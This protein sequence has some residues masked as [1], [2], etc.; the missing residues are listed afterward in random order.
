[1]EEC[2]R[3]ARMNG[4]LVYR[5]VIINLNLSGDCGNYKIGSNCEHNLSLRPLE[6]ADGFWNVT[7]RSQG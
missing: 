6:F 2:G 7:N 1:M 3:R 4:Y 5:E